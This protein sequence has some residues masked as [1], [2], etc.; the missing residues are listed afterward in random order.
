MT[1]HH[2]F[3][4]FEDMPSSDAEEFERE[5]VKEIGIEWR[6]LVVNYLPK[7]GGDFVSILEDF[8]EN[9]SDKATMLASNGASII[10]GLFTLLAKVNGKKE[11]K[12]IVTVLRDVFEN[13]ETQSEAIQL[14]LNLAKLSPVSGVPPLPFGPLFAL[15]SRNSSELY[16]ISHTISVLNVLLSIEDAHEES[17]E[18]LA[19]WFVTRS[20][21]LEDASE[22]EVSTI[23]ILLRSFLSTQTNRL[24]YSKAQGIPILLSLTTTHTGNATVLQR[25]YDALY[26]VWLLSFNADVRASL[27]DPTFIGNLAQIV[28]R[29][30]KEKVVRLGLATLR[31]L[32][33]VGKNNELMIAAGVLKNVPLLAAK[34]KQEWGD[35]DITEDLEH[36]EKILLEHVDEMSNFDRYKFEVLSRKL[37]WTPSHRSERFWKQ[38]FLRFEEESFAVLKILKDL[39][40]SNENQIISIAA[41]DIGEF[42]RFHPRGRQ[43]V[44]HLDIKVAVMELLKHKEET[45][46]NQALLTLQKVMVTSWEFLAVK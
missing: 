36:I 34:N 10:G 40:K 25:L 44:N 30:K 18:S 33:D 11:L 2:S 37:E 1:T 17:I 22:R 19:S 42:V 4:Y 26:C 35:E 31:N 45:V 13:E 32:L 28:K 39:L 15:L 43:I 46:R 9:L 23:L 12:Y 6:P 21:T 7:K 41:W 29:V 8:D 5:E 24:A 3:E 38:N 20:K 16:I 14:A 27:T